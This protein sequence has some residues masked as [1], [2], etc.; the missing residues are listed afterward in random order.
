MIAKIV[1]MVVT[2]LSII[3]IIMSYHSGDTNSILVFMALLLFNASTAMQ[4]KLDDYFND[5]DI[6]YM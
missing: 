6:D 4:L 3:G 2:L 1:T 5:E